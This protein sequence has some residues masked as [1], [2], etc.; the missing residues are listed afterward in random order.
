MFFISISWRFPRHTVIKIVRMEQFIF[1]LMKNK[2]LHS[3]I[4]RFYRKKMLLMSRKRGTQQRM[5][6]INIQFEP[7]IGSRLDIKW[8]LWNRNSKGCNRLKNSLCEELN[9]KDL[10]LLGQLEKP[11]LW[12][13]VVFLAI[14]IPGGSLR[15]ICRKGVSIRSHRHPPV[16]SIS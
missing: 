3:R 4:P 8:D 7:W 9:L 14:L 13:V 16:N 12:F 1:L 2:I 10:S 15:Q 6:Q 11:R 5:H